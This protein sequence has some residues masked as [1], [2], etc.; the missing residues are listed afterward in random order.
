MTTPYP[1]P[2]TSF[3]LSPTSI[4]A[5]KIITATAIKITIAT[6]IK[7]TTATAPYIPLSL[8]HLP[9]LP[10]PLPAPPLL[11]TG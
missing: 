8:L 11:I 2:C 6:A 7:I 1:Q 9:P 10:L 3:K 4:T 5:T